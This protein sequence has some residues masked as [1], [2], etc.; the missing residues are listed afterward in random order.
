MPATPSYRSGLLRVL[1]AAVSWGFIP[2][3]TRQV[4]AS[5][6]VIVFWRVVFSALALALFLGVR[7]RLGEFGA[8]SRRQK[9]GIAAG[10]AIL[11]LNWVLFFSA[12]E[13]TDV[14]IAVLLGYAGPV[15]VTA[16]TP[17]AER[18]PFDRR[19]LVPLVLALVG[20]AVIVDPA[21]VA[22]TDST[23]LI[24]D[25]LA[26]ASAFTYA[27]GFFVSKRLLRGVPATT[28]MLAEHTV[29]AA[30]LLP[31]VA[32]L[33]AP[34]GAVAWG[35]LV[36]LGVVM[37]AGTGFLFLSGLHAVRPDHASILTYAE[38]FSA[39]VLA[40]LF[41]GEPITLTTVIGGALIIAG[42]LLVGRMVPV[43]SIEAP[44]PV[45]DVEVL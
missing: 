17:L 10:G 9:L 7:G 25:A 45:T 1:I 35:S 5:A 29:V 3:L 33:P 44:G 20:T 19:V 31:I 39:V 37:T 36:T 30:L 27:I 15:F 23:H 4:Q 40:A 42:G 43:P 11:A 8:L 22:A 13:R 16:L 34:S 28:F 41:L 26:F 24:G 38:A 12:L 32:F 2:L 21:N 18:V 14:A 6:F